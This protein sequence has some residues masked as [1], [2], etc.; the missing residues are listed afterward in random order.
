M[1]EKIGNCLRDEFARAQSTRMRRKN[2]LSPLLCLLMG[3]AGCGGSSS[4]NPTTGTTGSGVDMAGDGGLDGGGTNVTSTT[5]RPTSI[6]TTGGTTY[7]GGA[8]GTNSY[9]F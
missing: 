5:S 1:I 4:P 2:F 9:S 8:G 6:S 7:K 3:V